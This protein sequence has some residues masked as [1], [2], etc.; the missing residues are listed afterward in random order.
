VLFMTNLH[1]SAN[2]IMIDY[3]RVLNIEN[4]SLWEK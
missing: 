4:Q 1:L 2:G 3:H